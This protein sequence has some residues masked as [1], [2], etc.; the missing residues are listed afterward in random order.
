M[1]SSINVEVST[2]ISSLIYSSKFF[3]KAPQDD[4]VAVKTLNQ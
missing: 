2:V 3:A 1:K 4:R